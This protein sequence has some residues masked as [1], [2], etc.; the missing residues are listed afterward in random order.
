MHEQSN[1]EPF[2][3]V[4][5]LGASSTRPLYQLTVHSTG[6]LMM[7]HLQ[8]TCIIL[9]EL[10]NSHAHFLGCLV[11]RYPSLRAYEESFLEACE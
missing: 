4:S 10:G 11:F 8:Q 6:S 3:T 5:L 7:H 9:Y 2:D 1:Q